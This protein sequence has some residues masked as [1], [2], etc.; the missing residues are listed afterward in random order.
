M[1]LRSP[2]AG[3]R[4]LLAAAFTTLSLLGLIV[5]P[6]SPV[7]AAEA[8]QLIRNGSVEE[9]VLF[10]PTGWDTTVSG[11]PTVRFAWDESQA[12]S[13]NRSMHIY[14]VSDVVPMWHNWNQYISGVNELGGKEVVLRV[15]MKTQQLTGQAYLL[16]QAYRDTVTIEALRT[17]E[18]RMVT[19]RKMKIAA[20]KD[21][22]V[23]LGWGR[24]YI[25]EEI[26]E[27]TPVEV[28]LYIPPSTNLLYIRAGIFGVGAVWFDDLSLEVR[29]ATPEKP[30]PAETNLLVNPGFEEG[31]AGWDFSLAPIDGTRVLLSDEAHSGAHSV[32]LESQGKP[33][34]QIISTVFQAFNTRQMSGKRV[35]L[36][37]WIKIEGLDKSSA[38]IRLFG[39]GMYGDYM[40]GAS[41]AYSNTID[42]THI[43]ME[44]DIPAD[45]YVLWSQAGFSTDVGRIWFDDMSL[46]IVGDAT[47]KP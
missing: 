44:K 42:W 12:H 39:T 30:F 6:C 35:R 33:P 26:P 8:Q 11:L 43:T 13:G 45:T 37:G 9:G 34:V 2:I 21:P 3:G 24:K 22:Q 23:E 41:Q 31:L 15:W 5:V 25:S 16:V 29:E 27:W 17:G 46:E 4:V 14:S 19:R 7:E 10:T 18:D 38:F 1:S 36:S 28:S 32:L 20:T 47:G 40:P